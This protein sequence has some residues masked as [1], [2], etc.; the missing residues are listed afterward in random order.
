[1]ELFSKWEK[2]LKDKDSVEATIKLL[3]AN[4]KAEL[5]TQAANLKEEMSDKISE[6]RDTARREGEGDWSFNIINSALCSLICNNPYYH[7]YVS[8][9]F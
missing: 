5:A 8:P 3:E 9:N 7:E 1:M 4:H 2:T 6:A